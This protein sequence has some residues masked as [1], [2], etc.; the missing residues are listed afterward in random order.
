MTKTDTQGGGGKPEIWSWGHRNIQGAALDGQGRLWT[1]EHGPE[2]GDELNRIERKGF[3]PV[4][5]IMVDLNGLKA[6]NDQW[7]HEVGD[8]L[9]RRVGEVLGKAIDKP[10]SAAR[11]VRPVNSTSSTST[12]RAPSSRTEKPHQDH[13]GLTAATME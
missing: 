3:R 2:G 10:S 5:I 9:L 1:I 11:I 13:G 6:T 7:G 8:A 4:T 12:Q